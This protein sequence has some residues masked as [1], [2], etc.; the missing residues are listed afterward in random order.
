MFA[1]LSNKFALAF[2]YCFV[3]LSA[4]IAWVVTVDTFLWKNQSH[5]QDYSFCLIPFVAV[6]IPTWFL[7]MVLALYHYKS[8]KNSSVSEFV[9]KVEIGLSIIF[10]LGSA[11]VSA[12]LLQGTR[13]HTSCHYVDHELISCEEDSAGKLIQSIDGNNL[14]AGVVF[15]FLTAFACLCVGVVAGIAYKNNTNNTQQP[16]QDDSQVANIV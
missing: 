11:L 14:M 5:F 16:K 15:G 3:A 4:L 13:T 8:A 1:L 6:F 9:L 12:F 10:T 7:G 2:A